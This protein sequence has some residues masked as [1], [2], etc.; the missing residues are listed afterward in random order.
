[1]TKLQII[2]FCVWTYPEKVEGH[3]AGQFTSGIC[4]SNVMGDL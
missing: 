3:S 1:M 4:A 2:L